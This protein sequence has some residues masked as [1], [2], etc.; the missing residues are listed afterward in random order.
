MKVQQ[1]VLLLTDILY[2]KGLKARYLTASLAFR[3]PLS[4]PTPSVFHAEQRG[5]RTF[6]IQT[7]GLELRGYPHPH[8]V[9]QHQQC[10]A[11]ILE[12]SS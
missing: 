9:P 7:L 3:Q 2:R 12:H 6:F 1:V 5:M 8:G 10:Q 11:L 4:Y